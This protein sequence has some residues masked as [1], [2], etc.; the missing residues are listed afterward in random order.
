[1][2]NIIRRKFI[3]LMNSKSNLFQRLIIE[4]KI[5]IFSLYHFYNKINYFYYRFILYLFTHKCQCYYRDQ[6]RL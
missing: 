1:M 4:S 2:M 3:K 6:N 5:I